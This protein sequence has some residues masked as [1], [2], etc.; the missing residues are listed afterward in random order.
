MPGGYKMHL[1][2]TWTSF[3]VPFY[4]LCAI[5]SPSTSKILSIIN[6]D[7][8]HMS[9]FNHSKTVRAKDLNFWEN[10]HHTLCVMCPMSN[11]RCHMS[12]VTRN[13]FLQSGEVSLLRVCYQ[14]G[15]FGLVF[16]LFL[17]K[18]RWHPIF[19]YLGL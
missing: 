17:C 3:F 19:T 9:L 8:S 2:I 5:S 7:N 4:H 18:T 15:L 10:Y 6:T 12:L 14:Q 11:V 13:F 16:R 1:E